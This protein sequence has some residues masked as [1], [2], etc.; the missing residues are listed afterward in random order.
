M[1][2]FVL[3]GAAGAAVY[4]L[5]LA[6]KYKRI[7]ADMACVY[8]GTVHRIIDIIYDQNDWFLRKVRLHKDEY[9]YVAEVLISEVRTVS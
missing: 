4:C 7:E 1:F 8:E 6:S 3:T 9:P 5:R 2:A